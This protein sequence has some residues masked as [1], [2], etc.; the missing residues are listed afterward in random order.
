VAGPPGV[1]D[2]I[3]AI[4]DLS[5][6][7]ADMVP[8]VRRMYRY[9]AGILVVWI[10][11]MAFVALLTF[12]A[13][14]YVSV[15]AI[16]GLVVAAIGLSLLRRTDRFFRSFAQRHRSIRL[17]RD[18]DPVVH[19][20]EG[21]TPIER[22]AR[23]LANSSPVVDAAVREN[24]S[25]VRYRTGLPAHGRTVPFDLVIEQPGG[26][27]ART[28][29][30]GARGFTIL[31]RLGPDRPSVIELS[32]L[33]ADA[34]AV[35]PRLSGAPVRLILLRPVPGPLAEDAYEYTVGHPVE[36]PWGPGGTKLNLEIISENPD[37]TYDFVPHVMGVP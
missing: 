12:A 1:E 33:E 24:P 25:I 5:D 17:L 37:R 8:V 3:S 32:Q 15:L 9:T 19:I 2:P 21:R 34:V 13:I 28:L 7:T 6:R 27:L 4:F 26:T 23:Y 36:V 14:P 29:G 20:P 22:L 31:A 30:V 35:T 11:L 10:V 16:V 18:A